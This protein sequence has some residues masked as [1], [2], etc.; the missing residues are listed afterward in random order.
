MQNE[1][2]LR[3]EAG[4]ASPLMTEELTSVKA[5][6][7]LSLKDGRQEE[8][9][10]PGAPQKRPVKEIDLQTV[11]PPIADYDAMTFQ[12]AFAELRQR[13]PTPAQSLP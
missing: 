4:T 11:L 9:Q 1:L 10:I 12:K 13:N 3:A 5:M 8:H 6:F 7:V 2:K